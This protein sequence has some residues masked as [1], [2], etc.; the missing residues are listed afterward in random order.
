MF[1]HQPLV[2]WVL[3]LGIAAAI[4][5]IIAS[6]IASYFNYDYSEKE[7]GEIAG[8]LKN[9]PAVAEAAVT[10]QVQVS[11]APIDDL[12]ALAFVILEPGVVVDPAELAGHCRS[13]LPEFLV[14]E[15]IHVVDSLPTTPNGKLDRAALVSGRT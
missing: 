12:R 4:Y 11:S 8:V 13:Q 14:P 1:I 6:V 2:R 3:G 9:H 7:L 15:A 10:V 5:F